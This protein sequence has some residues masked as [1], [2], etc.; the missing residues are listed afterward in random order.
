ME[1]NF[2]EGIFE[3][4]FPLLR[5]LIPQLLEDIWED[6]LI[7]G[8][9]MVDVEEV[10]M[11]DMVDILAPPQEEIIVMILI[12]M[13]ET[14][15]VATQEVEIEIETEIDTMMTEIVM[16]IGIDMMTDTGEKSICERDLCRITSSCQN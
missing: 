1:V 10:V 6:P 16:M 14:D 2:M 7:L 11:I 12:M 3:P 13:I 8:I 4:I 5:D 9:S 15:I